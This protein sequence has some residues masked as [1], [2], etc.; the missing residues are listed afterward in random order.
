MFQRRRG[1][2]CP[3]V[4]V[5]AEQPV[6]ETDTPGCALNHSRLDVQPILGGPVNA[7][8]LLDAVFPLDLRVITV[9]DI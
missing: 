3:Y 7:D 9:A 8:N 6:N 5:G 2:Q 1:Y 4:L